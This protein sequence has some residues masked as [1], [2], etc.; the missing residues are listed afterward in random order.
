M[1]NLEKIDFEKNYKLVENAFSSQLDEK[2]LP[3]AINSVKLLLREWELKSRDEKKDYSQ[4][5]KKDFFLK[6]LELI[7]LGLDLS[8]VAKQ[9]YWVPYGGTNP[10]LEAMISPVG[11]IN[12]LAKSNLYATLN[13]V[14]EGEDFKCDLALLEISHLSSLTATNKIIGAYCII[15]D[16]ARKIIAVEVIKQYDIDAI[17]S[18]SKPP[19]PRYQGE[20]VPKISIF[21]TKWEGEMW[22]KSVLKKAMKKIAL[23]HPNFYRLL[24]YDNEA[25]FNFKNE[26]LKVNEVNNG[27]VSQNAFKQLTGGE[28][29]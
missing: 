17:K 14:Y 16:S 26:R 4:Y 7:K 2:E 15:R 1:D 11:Y 8:P 6:C 5:L 18:A 28:N 9:L 21:W 29:D 3:V 10:K 20:N 23:N 24:D 12:L 22:K 27:K 13:V 19:K 25:E